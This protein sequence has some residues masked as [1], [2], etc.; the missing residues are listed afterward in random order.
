MRTALAHVGT[1]IFLQSRVEP[2]VSRQA[3]PPPKK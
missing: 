3:V 1:P 2:A